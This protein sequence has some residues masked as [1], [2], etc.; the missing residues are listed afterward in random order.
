MPEQVFAVEHQAGDDVYR[1]YEGMSLETVT[2]LLTETGNGF[3]LLTKEQFDA[4]VAALPP[5][6]QQG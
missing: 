1:S 6:R 2:A 3:D 5:A 4:A